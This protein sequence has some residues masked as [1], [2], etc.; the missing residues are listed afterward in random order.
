[1]GTLEEAAAIYRSEP[2]CPIC[3]NSAH[4]DGRTADGKQRYECSKCGKRFSSLTGTI[5]EHRKKELPTWVDFITIMIRNGSLELAAEICGITHS[6]TFEWRHRIFATVDGCQDKI[7][8]RDRIWID[9]AYIPDNSILHGS[10]WVRKRGLSKGRICISAAIDI[11]KNMVAVV[12]GNGKPSSKRIKD[13]PLDHIEEGATIVHDKEKA[14]DSLVKAVKCTSE[15]YKANTKDPVY[16]EC[17]MLANNL[18]S[19]IKRYLWRYVGMKPVNLQ[20]YL[21]WFVYRFRVKRDDE[22]W[23]KTERVIRHLLRVDAYYRSS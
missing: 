19:W 11:H 13:A 3:E 7:K 20:S 4:M 23:P 18:C 5:F 8:L 14:H 21:N 2:T 6:T 10:D 17:M 9:E 22:R 12:C 16:L 1:M 15:A